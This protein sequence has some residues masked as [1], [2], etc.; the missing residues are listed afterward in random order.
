MIE[1]LKI[2]L[3]QLNPTVGDIDANAAKIREARAG[4]AG[5]RADLVVF[6]ELFVTGYPPEELVLKP[7]LL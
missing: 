3:A 2:G 5:D 1:R 7:A 6:S 4:F